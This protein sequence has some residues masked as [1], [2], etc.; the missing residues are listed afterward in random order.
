MTKLIRWNFSEKESYLEFTNDG[1]IWKN[2]K[3]SPHFEKDFDSRH[4]KGYRTAQKMLQAGY[5]YST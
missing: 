5:K 1:H 3:K 4:S 2:Y